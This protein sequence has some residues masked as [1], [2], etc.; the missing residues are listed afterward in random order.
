VT[1]AFTPERAGMA[2]IPLTINGVIVEFAGGVG[3]DVD[4]KIT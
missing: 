4:Q 1:L 2:H 3:N